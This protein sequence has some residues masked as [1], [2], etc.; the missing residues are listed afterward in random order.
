VISSTRFALPGVPVE[1]VGGS[2]VVYT[3][4]DGR[5]TLDLAPGTYELKVA[6]DGYQEQTIRVEA[7][8]GQRPVTADIGLSMTRFAETVTVTA[9]ALL[10]A[11]TSSA[12]AQL[13][14]RKNAQVI[15]DN[16]GAQ[17]MRAN[18]DGDAAA[19]MARVTGLSVVDNQYVFVRGLGERYSNTTLSGSVLPTTEPDRKV[20]PLDIFPSGLLDSVQVAKSYSVDKSAEFAGGLVQI[21]PLKFPSRPVFDVSFGLGYNSIS[22]GRSM[23][24]SPLGSRDFWGFDN[25]ARSLPGSFPTSKIVRRGIYTPE[26]GFSGDEITSYGRQ[27]DNR[28]TPVSAEGSPGQSWGA[29]YG[30]RWGKLGLVASVTHSY[31]ESFVQEQRNFY[32]VEE[33]GQLEA[34]T[35]YDFEIGTQKAQVGAVF[36][37]AYAFSPNHR[38][39]VENFYSHSGKDEGRVFEGPNTENNLYLRNYRLQFIEEG[40]MSNAVGGEH[41]FPTVANSRIDWRASYARAARDE[42]DLR[43][44]LY[45]APLGS[46]A[47]NRVFRLLDKSQS[48]FRMFNELDDDTLDV[49]ANWSVY[50]TANGRPVQLKAGPSYIRRERDASSRRFRYIPTNLV[51]LDFTLP[52]EQLYTSSNV[53]PAFRFNEETRPVD[54]YDAK[55]ETVAAY[56]MADLAL[57]HRARLI[58]GVRVEKFDLTVNTFD[59][60]GL[61]VDRVTATIDST[62]VFPS[63]N[64]VYALQPN[65]NL[66]LGFS[67]TVNRPEFREL[68]AFEFTDV[69]GNRS[70]RGNPDL[71]RALIQNLDARWEIFTGTRDVFAVSA[72]MKRF[73]DPIERV[74]TG[75][76]Q[77]VATFENADSARNFGFEVEAARALGRRFYVAANY[78]FVDSEITLTEGLRR[79]QT[80]LVRPLAG[81]SRHLFNLI[82]GFSVGDFSTRLLYNFFDDR[83]SDVGASGAPDVVE[84]A[85]GI[86]DLV[87]SQRLADRLNVRVSLDNLT[88]A[89]YGFTQG[90][91]VQRL[92]KLG[93]TVSVSFGYSWF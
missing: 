59:P 91:E 9:D 78:T 26:V 4:V 47:E 63:L 68:A 29:T 61:F 5:Y 14:E 86:V 31:K 51:P 54:A 73:D 46:T 53:G 79:T 89:D 19:A 75:S 82:G 57:S 84:D 93:R 11:V 18:G 24:Q 41:F 32:R 69:V 50:L 3:D 1:V 30:S 66:R 87:F 72:F 43:E 62:D 45:Q 67:Q 80:S 13:V 71:K 88:N 39:S 28:W 55:Q 64:L 81:Q 15:T 74:I 22:T 27:L 7:T 65:M 83:I 92:F 37:V 38:L 2:Q 34:V 44:S 42:P 58:G 6:M 52:P 12:A 21:Q 35:E 70:I 85:R 40:L 60:F 20:V 8:A 76:A 33:G 10:D 48:G 17:D 49:A 16:M 56:G 25:G 23:P 36:N 90:S 77:P